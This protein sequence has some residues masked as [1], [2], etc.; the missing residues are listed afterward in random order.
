MGDVTLDSIL[1]MQNS[2]V[3]S[4]LHTVLGAGLKKLL[5]DR[6]RDPA[7]VPLWLPKYFNLDKTKA[8]KNASEEQRANIISGSS[9]ALL[10][11]ALYIEQSGMA[12]AA[13]M[14]IMADTIEERML[15]GLFA[16]DETTHYHQVRQFLPEQGRSCEPSE[17]HSLLSSLIQEGDRE[18]LVFVIQVVLEGWGLTHY[19]SL[20]QGC[21]SE[22]FTEVLK[23]ILRDEARHHGSGVIL[24]RDRGLPDASR[25]Y[26]NQILTTFLYMVQLG[27]QSVLSAVEQATG[28]LTRSQKLE[29]FN[30]LDG[31]AQSQERLNLLKGLMQEDG[32][33]EVTDYLESKGSFKA[34]R[35]E[36]CI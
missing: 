14:S 4:R 23:S 28:G 31:T 22:E 6:A 29:L 7:P 35:A 20:A 13:K 12:Y 15:Y 11:E 19:R 8:F 21:Q 18:S 36:E 33:T 26:V 24:C 17:F 3:E 32:F 34:M 5:G 1:E 10:E 9:Q 27:P 16:A 25:D 2:D 30:E